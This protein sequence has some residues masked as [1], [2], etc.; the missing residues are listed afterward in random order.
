[1]NKDLYNF[2]NALRAFVAFCEEIKSSSAYGYKHAADLKAIDTSSLV[3]K[4]EH[5]HE[6]EMDELYEIISKGQRY[7]SIIERDLETQIRIKEIKHGEE[8]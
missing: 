7:L 1:M 5:L 6:K 8:K 2:S 4:L 3:E